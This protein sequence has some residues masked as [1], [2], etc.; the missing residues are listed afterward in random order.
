MKVANIVFLPH[1]FCNRTTKLRRKK[2]KLL[3][4]A[5][6]QMCKIDGWRKMMEGGSIG[7]FSIKKI[8]LYL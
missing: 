8:N 6:N 7:E 3:Y 1:F 4:R 2:R 5:Q